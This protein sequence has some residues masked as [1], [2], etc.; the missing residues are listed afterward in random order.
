[1]DDVDYYPSH[2]RTSRD[3]D[4]ATSKILLVN[5]KEAIANSA[6]LIA[7]TLECAKGQWTFL[8]SAVDDY[9]KNIIHLENYRWDPD[10]CIIQ[11]VYRPDRI[12]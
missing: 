8:K 12:Q 11:D 6:L 4:G 5:L 9:L 10:D 1:M 2:Q 3:Y 7:D